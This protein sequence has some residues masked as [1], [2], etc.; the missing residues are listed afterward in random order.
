MNYIVELPKQVP[1]VTPS[2]PPRCM[3]VYGFILNRTSIGVCIYIYFCLLETVMLKPKSPNLA[4]PLELKN[5]FSALMSLWTM[6][7]SCYTARR[8]I[9]ELHLVSVNKRHRRGKRYSPGVW[10]PTR[11]EKKGFSPP[12]RASCPRISTF[13]TVPRPPRVPLSDSILSTSRSLRTVCNSETGFTR[14]YVKNGKSY[15]KQ[16]ACHWRNLVLNLGPQFFLS[17]PVGATMQF[18]LKYSE[19]FRDEDWA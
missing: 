13:W 7:R 17:K 16:H 15:V 14:Y 19:F 4:M 11:S 8:Q 9:N 6:L 12:T 5:T 10:R 2:K 3:M 18:C 1:G